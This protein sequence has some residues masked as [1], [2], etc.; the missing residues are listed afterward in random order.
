M[1]TM[2]VLDVRRGPVG[3]LF[4]ADG[5]T[6]SYASGIHTTIEPCPRLAQR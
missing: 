4:F 5:R 6:P 2:A 1:T 3:P